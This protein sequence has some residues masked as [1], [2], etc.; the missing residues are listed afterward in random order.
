MAGF[1]DILAAGMEALSFTEEKT[2]EVVD[3][4]VEQGKITLD[5]GKELSSQLRERGSEAAAAAAGTVSPIEEAGLKA[6]LKTMSAE[7]RAAYVERVTNLAAEVDQEAATEVEAEV[8]DVAEEAPEA[9]EE[10]AAE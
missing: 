10:P 7:D 8:V 5:Q 1:R 9:A 2:K 3:L 4:L 6:R